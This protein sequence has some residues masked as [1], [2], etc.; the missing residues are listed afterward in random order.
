MSY[1]LSLFPIVTILL[2]SGVSLLGHS[3]PTLLDGLFIVS[4][5]Q[6]HDGV[7]LGVVEFIHRVGSHVQQR[8]PASLLDLADGRQPDDAG[9]G[10]LPGVVLLWN[11]WLCYYSYSTTL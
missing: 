6:N 3:C 5:Q 1:N 8:V 11:I 10:S 4:S 7:K 9:L 2:S